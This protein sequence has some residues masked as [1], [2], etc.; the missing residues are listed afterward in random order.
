MYC[1]QME[2]IKIS[3]YNKNVMKLQC[4]LNYYNLNILNYQKHVIVQDF[5]SLE[6]IN[7]LNYI[8]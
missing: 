2:E 6:V 7:L 3:K 8:Q 5:P 4:K 1:L